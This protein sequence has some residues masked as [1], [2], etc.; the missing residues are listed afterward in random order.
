MFINKCGSSSYFVFIILI[1][2]TTE[3]LK[4]NQ[5]RMIYAGL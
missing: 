2:G 5:L 4:F 3:M 1:S